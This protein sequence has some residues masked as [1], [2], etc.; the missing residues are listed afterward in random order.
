[1]TFSQAIRSPFLRT[2]IWN[3]RA[4]SLAGLVLALTMF[5]AHRIRVGEQNRA[6]AGFERLCLD[7]REQIHEHL[8][9]HAEFLY[10]GAALFGAS[11]H[12]TRTEWRSFIGSHRLRGN[13]SDVTGVGYSTL[14]SHEKL[15]Q[16]ID[17][18][19]KAGFKDVA[20]WPA[21]ERSDYSPV[22]YLEPASP[23]A[24]S[25]IGFDLFSEPMLRQSMAEARDLNAVT[26]S[27]RVPL[28]QNDSK[29][30][31]GVVM[32]VPV[33]RA[34]MPLSN[35]AERRE[36]IQGWVHSQYQVEDLLRDI[37]CAKRADCNIAKFEI[38]DRRSSSVEPVSYTPR[39]FSEAEPG[40]VFQLPLEFGG[41]HLAVRF[42]TADDNALKPEFSR[43]PLVILS[44]GAIGVLL[45]CIVLLW[46]EAALR[47][48]ELNRTKLALHRVRERFEL[49][50]KG[51]QDGLWDWNL[52]TGETYFS[53]RW[54]SMLGYEKTE[55]EP[56]IRA[57]FDL[58]HPDD[59]E[60]VRLEV[61]KIINGEDKKLD[62]E[63]RM[64]HKNGSYVDVLT[65]GFVVRHKETGEPVRMVG[66]HVDIT[67]H[68]HQQRELSQFKTTLD[69]TADCI[70]MYHPDTLRVFYVNRAAIMQIGCPANELYEKRVFDF[71]GKHDEQEFRDFVKPLVDGDFSSLRYESVHRDDEDREIPVEV[72]LQYVDPDDE[73]ARFVAVVRDISDYKEHA[74]A[75]RM[76]KEHAERAS[77]AKTDFLATMSHELRTPLNGVAGMTELLRN[78]KLDQRQRR[79][80]DAC[81]NSGRLLLSLINDI[82]DFSKIE[83]GK[84]ELVEEEFESLQLIGDTVDAMAFLAE[85]KGLGLFSHVS[86]EV[87]ARLTGDF[88][89]LRQILVNL[90]GN[91]I[92]FTESG[93]VNVRVAIVGSKENPFVRFT[94]SD[95]GVGIRE[96]QIDKVYD[97]FTQA[98]SSTTRKTGGTGLGLSISKYLVE[99]MG[100]HL[101]AKSELG[102]GSVFAFELP[103][104]SDSL[105]EVKSWPKLCNR[106]ALLLFDAQAAAGNLTELL[107]DWSM[108]V[109]VAPSP[110]EADKLLQLAI[111]RGQPF[112]FFVADERSLGE[113]KAMKSLRKKVSDCQPTKT[114]L[115]RD[116]GKVSSG[117]EGEQFDAI[118]YTPLSQSTLLDTLSECLTGRTDTSQTASQGSEADPMESLV[119]FRILLAE[120]NTISQLFAREV[121]QQAGLLCDCVVN[122]K[123]AIVSARS[124]RYD[125]ILMDCQMPIVD[126]LEATRTIRRMEQ[127]GRMK[128]HTPI[129]ALTANAIKGDRERCLEA[130]MDEYISKPYSPKRLLQM[131]SDMLCTAGSS[132][133]AEG[134]HQHR[135]TE[136]TLADESPLPDMEG[137][138]ARCMNNTAFALELLVDFEEDLPKQLD[139]ITRMVAEGNLEAAG[140]SAHSLKGSAGILGAESV[141]KCASAIDEKSKLGL[142]EDMDDLVR[143]LNDEIQRFVREMPNAKR[144]IASMSGVVS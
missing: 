92:K 97:S 80:V 47:W 20:I 8:E 98:D 37:G 59:L 120:D 76:A 70:F 79:F 75:L 132:P 50:M 24:E 110:E 60:R 82:L 124:Q 125:L 53:M 104:Q 36:A 14:V 42:A 74:I 130:G 38:L 4:W 5:A 3:W 138:L 58:I 94:V 66:T 128:G 119:G 135:A 32:F 131:I 12:V 69:V 88:T 113:A 27:G 31:D 84:L 87:P 139:E 34:G 17:E 26:L 142:L 134:S 52:I 73:P 126:G 91:A 90:I 41:Q 140:E 13:H 51:S 111:D 93:E 16:Y 71:E 68:K 121:M 65:R 103:C 102:V 19:R 33:Y 55:M 85:E 62:F 86:P 2:R 56:H 1:M 54:M 141:R 15:D 144:E 116:H 23:R 28:D 22:V 30:N 143:E 78:T 39:E 57:A 45:F 67:A 105:S 6:R 96:D 63:L 46:Q 100:G 107:H 18:I 101:V 122:G 35:L 43:V 81:Q 136:S 83:A 109:Y 129:I 61:A 117:E 44:G 64:R 118:L 89:R 48:G 7:T 123:E 115:I 21:G 25:Q 137:L 112:D 10:S 11:Q 127:D 9:D 95:T 133:V 114:L 106:R 40:G 77:Q 29:V 72:F 99:R 108:S 49:A